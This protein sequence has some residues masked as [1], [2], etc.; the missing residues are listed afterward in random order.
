MGKNPGHYTLFKAEMQLLKFRASKRLMWILLLGLEAWFLVPTSS[1]LYKSLV[2]DI[3]AELYVTPRDR[4]Y[5]DLS[6]TAKFA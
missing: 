5:A 4:Y 1:A 2:C 6:A 3:I